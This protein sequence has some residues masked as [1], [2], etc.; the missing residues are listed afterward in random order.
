MKLK[1][2]ALSL[3]VATIAA[4]TA[5]HAADVA[6]F[7][8]VVNSPTVATLVS[9]VDTGAADDGYTVGGVPGG[10]RLH[11]RLNYKAGANASTNSAICEEVNYFL[12]SSQ[13]DIQTVDIGGNFGGTTKGVLFNDASIN[14]DW[15][16]N[17]TATIN[18]MLGK[19]AGVQRGVL[20]V[21]NSN[22]DGVLNPGAPVGQTIYGEAMILDI[23]AGAA[24][25]YQA[26]LR[27]N[28]GVNT[29]AA[30]DFSLAATNAAG[31]APDILTFMPLAE[32]TTRVFVT[33]VN[34]LAA[35]PLLGVDGSSAANW[36]RHTARV[37][38]VT[39]TGVAYDRDENL[40]S[41]TT[42]SNVT[43]VGFVDVGDLMT[44]GA[45]AVLANGGWGTLSIQ[46]GTG[47]AA[48]S[49]NVNTA[50]ATKL[51]YNTSGNLNGQGV[52][53]TFNNG[54]IMR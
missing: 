40:V 3:A 45:K 33:P 38:L 22:S 11:W 1:M 34:S 15:D 6:M 5:A 10:S 54:F 51:E 17:T 42:L 48:T 13:N 9:I 44:A 19:A 26:A 39:G 12:P 46:Q 41:G 31:S 2:K 18:Y 32:T 30:F 7:P 4:G 47:A 25:G 28:G 23:S 37:G 16:A 35:T 36:D 20:F 43:C 21:H 52:G 50:V 29:A 14:N 27:D 49:F 24:W 53:G 8:Y